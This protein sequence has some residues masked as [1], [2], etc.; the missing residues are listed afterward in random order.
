MGSGTPR[1]TS[2]RAKNVEPETGPETP[3]GISPPPVTE[4]ELTVRETPKIELEKSASPSEAA[5]SE[6]PPVPERLPRLNE[7]ISVNS[8]WRAMSERYA[9]RAVALVQGAL[10]GA[11][12]DSGPYDGIGGQRTRTALT[13]FALDHDTVLTDMDSLAEALD[14]LGFDV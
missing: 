4:V 3:S 13:A 11:G 8:V 2:S 12:Y 7:R 10:V 5:P 6:Q 9:S 1:S 14:A